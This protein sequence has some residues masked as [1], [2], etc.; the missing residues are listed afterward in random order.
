MNTN[1]K[2]IEIKLKEILKNNADANMIDVDNNFRLYYLTSMIYVDKLV[3]A[4]KEPYY[5]LNKDYSQFISSIMNE[6]SDTSN[7]TSMLTQGMVI[8]VFNNKVYSTTLA[9]KKESRKIDEVLRESVYEGPLSGFVENVETN[10]NIIRQ[11]YNKKELIVKEFKLGTISKYKSYLIYDREFADDNIIKS[12]THRLN[13]ITTPMVQSL[14][15]LQQIL[16]NKQHLCPRILITERFDRTVKQISQGKIVIILNGAPKALIAPSTFNQFIASADNY[17][18]HPIPSLFLLLLRYLALLAALILPGL[19]I[20]LSAYNTEIMRVQIALSIAAS[21]AGVPYPSYV[22][23]LIMLV[24]MEF[25]IEASLRLPKNIGQAGTTVG[26]IILGQAAT[27]A[28][29]VSNVMII[30]VAAVAI[31]N[32]VIPINSMNLTI[33]VSKYILLF[34]AS[35]AGLA[36]LFIGFLA[37]MYYLF[38][39]HSL[40]KPFFNPVGSFNISHTRAFFRKGQT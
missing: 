20:A 22:E 8:G 36:G 40:G 19:Y 12:I 26:G 31:S 21:R 11:F 25:L 1:A 9:A 28:N 7:I 29:L 37:L 35:I 30:I 16:D 38:T 18:L 10:L 2:N 13:S 34:L 5:N 39:L 6:F 14:T 15:E 3:S 32:F 24:M 4:I 17:Y 23:V 27:Q 33:R